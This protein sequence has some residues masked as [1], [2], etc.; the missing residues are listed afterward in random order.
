M[1]FPAFFDAAPRLSVIDPLSAF[2]GASDG[3][4]I[5]YGYADA[6][7]LAGHSCPTV[8]GAYLMTVRGLQ[9]L[10][11]AEPPVRG[12]V[13]VAFR[14]PETA[15]VTGVMGRV[16]ALL[17]GAAGEDGFKGI[18]GRFDRRGLLRFAVPMEGDM[19]LQRQD[20]GTGVQMRFNAALVPSPAEIRDLLPAVLHGHGDADDALRFQALW[21]DRVKRLLVDHADD[22]ALITVTPWLGAPSA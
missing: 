18:G 17:T 15:G 22:P 14:D 10:Y 6:V 13:A 7:K 5:A 12:N 2:L 3:G 4:T 9:A 16:A 11:G 20:T 8:A 21:Q 1:T 19:A